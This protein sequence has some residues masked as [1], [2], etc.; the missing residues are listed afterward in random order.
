MTPDDLVERVALTQD[1]LKVLFSYNPETGLFRRKQWRSSNAVAGSV[2]GTIHTKGYIAIW[3]NGRRQ[4]A[5]KLAWLYVYGEWPP[6]TI[7]HINGVK[8]D[9]RIANLRIATN[10]Q[11]QQN[12]RHNAANTSGMIGVVWNKSLKKWQAQIGLNKKK[13]YLGVFC[14]FDDAVSA[15]RKAEEEIHPFNT[16]GMIKA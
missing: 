10:A 1:E 5:H 13:I 2:A 4:M 8:S 14:S 9:N 3:I 16:R 11:N 6:D 15:R 12:L 7:D